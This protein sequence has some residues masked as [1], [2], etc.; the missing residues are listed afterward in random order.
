MI[1]IGSKGLQE[2]A[3]HDPHRVEAPQGGAEGP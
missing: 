1:R 2:D 3:D